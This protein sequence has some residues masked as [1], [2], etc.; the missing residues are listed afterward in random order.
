MKTI[1]ATVK[2]GYLKLIHVLSQRKVEKKKIVF[3]L[4]FPTTSGIILER[5]APY[6]KDDLVIGYT[7]NSA[8]LA[9]TY[10]K[11]GCKIYSLAKKKIFASKI[12]ALTKNADVVLCDNY[13]AFLAGLQ[14]SENT[15]V[16]QLWHADG[17]VKSFG[18]EAKYALAA[19]SEDK[20]R[21]QAVYERFTHYVVGSKKMMTIFKESYQTT[22]AEFL[23]FGYLPTDIYFDKKSK[24]LNK[25]KFIEKFGT[26]KTLL[27]A[28]TYREN[29]ETPLLDFETLAAKLGNQWQLLAHPHPHDKVL[30]AKLA[31][32]KNVVTDFET[33]SL[34][35]LLQNADCLISDYSSVPF[36]YALANPKGKLIYY[37][38]DFDQYNETVGLQKDFSEWLPKVLTTDEAELIQ[39]ISAYPYENLENFNKLWN[40]YNKGDACKQLIEW[41]ENR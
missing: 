27:Y 10:Q 29:Y 20:K 37:C 32:Y 6:F 25:K 18:L 23:P 35:A 1:S 11:F 19:S 28:P 39:L 16:L 30:R 21:Y 36:E 7:A 24:Q 2:H 8:S 40:T 34:Q 3:L 31:T 5:L 13:F 14:F 38:P 15:A 4:S 9:Q 12:I 33:L 17:A 22:T 26:K 41:I